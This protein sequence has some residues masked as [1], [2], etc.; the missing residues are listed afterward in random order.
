MSAARSCKT[1]SPST[2]HPTQLSL[3]KTQIS[4]E[5]QK[6]WSNYI[7]NLYNKPEHSFRP[8]KGRDETLKTSLDLHGLTIQQAFNA[9]RQFLEEHNLNGSRMAVIVTGKG[10]KICDELPLWV[11]NLGFVR[12]CEPI[13][14]ST[15]DH[16]A[17]LIRLYARR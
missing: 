7:Q 10:G 8:K 15:G 13:M 16:G 11:E 3:Q 17:Y 9:A 5:D 1:N 6:V 14:D 2:S 12:K 4:Q